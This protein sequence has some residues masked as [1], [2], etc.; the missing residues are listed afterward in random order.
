M[1][2]ENARRINVEVAVKKLLLKIS[3]RRDVDCKEIDFLFFLCFSFFFFKEVLHLVK[4]YVV[5]IL[6]RG[7]NVR[8][9]KK[10]KWDSL[11]SNTTCL[12]RDGTCSQQSVGKKKRKKRDVELDRLYARL[13]DR[14]TYRTGEMRVRL[15]AF[16]VQDAHEKPSITPNDSRSR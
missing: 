14:D 6:L 16:E 8:L 2:D 7:S 5:E 15:L 1:A 9:L 10:P 3:Q 4:L 12:D 11:F 13:R